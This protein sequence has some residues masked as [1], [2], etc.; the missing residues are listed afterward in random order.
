MSPSTMTQMLRLLFGMLFLTL[1]DIVIS[2]H[3]FYCLHIKIVFTFIIY[4]YFYQQI[5][6]YFKKIHIWKLRHS[7]VYSF[8]SYFIVGSNL[9]IR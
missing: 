6:Y 3:L 2:F 1:D 4:L 5:L 7:Y 8:F 9:Q